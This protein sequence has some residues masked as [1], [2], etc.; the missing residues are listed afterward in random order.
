MMRSAKG[1]LINDAQ[2]CAC[3]F[4]G[5]PDRQIHE[6]DEF[7]GIVVSHFFKESDVVFLGVF[8]DGTDMIRA[9]PGKGNIDLPAVSGRTVTFRYIFFRSRLL[10]ILAILPDVIPSFEASSPA[11]T[12]LSSFESQ[13]RAASSPRVLCC[14]KTFDKSLEYR[15]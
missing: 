7:P 6:A 8:I 5:G 14:S 1:F 10:R 3:Y 12:G 15:K 13:K 2:S 9:G 11:E 4:G